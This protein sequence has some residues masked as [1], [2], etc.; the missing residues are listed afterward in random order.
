MN[1]RTCSKLLFLLFSLFP[2]PSFPTL[3]TR[4]ATRNNEEPPVQESLDKSS[5]S[6]SSIEIEDHRF[7]LQSNS[8]TMETYREKLTLSVNEE[9]VTREEFRPSFHLGEIKESRIGNPFDA[10][11]HFN[12]EGATRDESYDSKRLQLESIVRDPLRQ[13]LYLGEEGRNDG[14]RF[15]QRLHPNRE[16][17]GGTRGSFEDQQVLDQGGA[18]YVWGKPSKFQGDSLKGEITESTLSN[19]PFSYSAV[20]HDRPSEE[21]NDFQKPGDELVY[22][23]ESSFTRTRTFPY[24]IHQPHVGYQQIDLVNDL[25]PYPVKKRYLSFFV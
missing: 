1:R 6:S 16:E 14:A 4:N 18:S 15:H 7:P 8:T 11:S 24:T 9:N 21:G 25:R 10:P 23:Q 3:E 13:N 19:A 17:D 12:L 22:V 5:S 2:N 20:F